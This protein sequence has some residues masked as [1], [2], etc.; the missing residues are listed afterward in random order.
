MAYALVGSVGTVASGTNS[1]S[2]T[3]AQATS[4]GH[5]L[6][7]WVAGSQITVTST[8][9]W[10]FIAAAATSAGIWYKANCAANETAPVFSG[11][12]TMFAALAEFSGGATAAPEDQHGFNAGATGVTPVS[13][14]NAAADVAAGE[15]VVCT[16]WDTLS[17]A[18]TTT[19]SHTYNNGATATGNLNNDGTSSLNHY[20]FSF[21]ITT[22][23]AA[24][25]SVSL[26]DSS[27]NLTTVT[28]RSASFLLAAAATHSL[29]YADQR[30]TRNSLLRR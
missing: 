27:K 8:Q 10:T 16:Q 6:V 26:A 17:K 22:G 14:A 18:G 25:D 1:A 13:V 12:G 24:A 2:P 19:T 28:G 30:V 4:V 23:N 5:L 20:R 7:A 15:L 3:F 21:G 11:S 29:V 9:S